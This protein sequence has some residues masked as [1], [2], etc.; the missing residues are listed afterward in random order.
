V[1]LCVAFLLDSGTFLVGETL[2]PNAGAVI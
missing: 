1:A 2:N